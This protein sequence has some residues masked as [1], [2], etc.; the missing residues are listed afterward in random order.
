MTSQLL[1]ELT[2]T[3]RFSEGK[4]SIPGERNFWS[5]AAGHGAKAWEA[6]TVAPGR[7]QRLHMRVLLRTKP[8]NWAPWP[9]GHVISILAFLP[10]SNAQKVEWIWNASLEPWKF[11]RA[12]GVRIEQPLDYQQLSE[13]SDA[14][15][16]LKAP[17][18]Q[19]VEERAN[20]RRGSVFRKTRFAKHVAPCGD[21]TRDFWLIRYQQI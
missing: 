2:I 5:L 4:G 1:V 20:W 21:R 9:I 10:K 19:L 8:I 15:I 14:R 11:K 6:S 17:L 3:N 13:P 18:T 7:K 16:E 12:G